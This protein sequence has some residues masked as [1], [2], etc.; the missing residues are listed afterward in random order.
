M[1]SL[2]DIAKKAIDSFGFK[3]IRCSTRPDKI[4][5]EVLTILKNYGVTAIELGAQSMCDD[6][7][8]Y[9]NRGHDAESVR[10]A[11]KLIKDFGF[12]LG[13]QMMTGLYKSDKDK[14]I[15]TAQEI[16]KLKPDTVRVYPTVTLENTYLADL[17]EAKIYEPMNLE[18]TVELCSYLLTLFEE[19]NIKVIRLG[20]H[21]SDEI[22]EKRVA[23]PYHPALREKCESFI[24]L[25]KVISELKD[26]EKGTYLY[27]INPKLVSKFSGQQRENINKLNILGYNVKLSQNKEISNYKLIERIGEFNP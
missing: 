6:V 14:D 19:N 4:D 18:N 16:I 13:L 8:L 10:I 21:A 27:E 24:I 20:L 25:N 1:L 23:G 11:S 9:N 5:N 17:Y 12:E 26:K 7:L 15:Y 2:L 3:G 22:T